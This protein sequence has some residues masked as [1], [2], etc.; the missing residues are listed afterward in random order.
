M[1]VN[2]TVLAYYN[3]V[4]H[5]NAKA[6]VSEYRSFSYINSAGN[7]CREYYPIKPK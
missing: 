7:L 6:K 5:Y 1:L 4:M 3:P 2:F